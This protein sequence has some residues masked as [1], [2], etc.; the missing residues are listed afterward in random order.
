M[1]NIIATYH[2]GCIPVP[3]QQYAIAVFP[4]DG[5]VLSEKNAF[6]TLFAFN[7]AVDLFR[8]GFAL[9]RPA[10]V[11]RFLSD[12]SISAIGNQAN[13]SVKEIKT[14]R[15]MYDW[16][17][18]AYTEQIRPLSIREMTELSQNRINLTVGELSENVATT[19]CCLQLDDVMPYMK[20]REAIRKVASFQGNLL[21]EALRT[22]ERTR[23]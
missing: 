15:V 18:T 2:W 9:H 16:R 12:D 14:P 6:S 8:L 22:L 3:T 13:Q 7:M 20:R 11:D 19:A 21:V 1:S 10:T 23:G 17:T 5:L 4:S